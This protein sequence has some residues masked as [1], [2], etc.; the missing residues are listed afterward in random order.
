M[1][2][3]T[4]TLDDE[5]KLI[6]ESVNTA[7]HTLMDLCNSSDASL[8][9]KLEAA[10]RILTHAVI[11]DEVMRENLEDDFEDEEEP[12]QDQAEQEEGEEEDA[13]RPPREGEA[14]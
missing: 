10:S 2:V 14:R 5:Q 3:R 7:L 9:L 1:G 12:D 6:S 4:L 13:D 11:N 8:D